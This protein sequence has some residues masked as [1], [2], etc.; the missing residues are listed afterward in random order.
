MLKSCDF[1]AHAEPFLRLGSGYSKIKPFALPAPGRFGP[2][3]LSKGERFAQPPA[4][5][6]Y[7]SER[8]GLS[9]HEI[10]WSNSPNRPD[11]ILILLVNREI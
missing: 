3:R 1:S 10:D 7:G 8:T 4:Q 2:G 6:A 5:S 11:H 9:K